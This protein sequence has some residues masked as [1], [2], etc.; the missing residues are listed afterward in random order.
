M[1]SAAQRRQVLGSL[2]LGAVQPN[3]VQTQIGVRAVRQTDR[4]AG[5]GDFF[6]GNRMGEVTHTAT[7]VLL[8]NGDAQQTQITHFGPQ[9][10]GKIVVAVNVGGPRCNLRGS[11]LVHRLPE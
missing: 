10:S 5:A 8:G 6:H 11:K 2:R 3:L 4:G 9:I 7:A 1:L